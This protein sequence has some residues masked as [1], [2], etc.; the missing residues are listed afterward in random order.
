MDHIGATPVLNALLSL[1]TI[2]GPSLSTSYIGMVLVFLYL[3]IPY[4]VL[5]VQAALERVPV[6]LIEASG[7][8]AP[9]P[10]ARFARSSCRWR[11]RA[12]WP[13]RSS[14]SR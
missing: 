8:L 1:P 11:C 13:G 7:D 12:W 6:S 4:M 14:R 10:G 3:W 5:P 9:A 2:G